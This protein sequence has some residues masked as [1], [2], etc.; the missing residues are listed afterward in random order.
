MQTKRKVDQAPPFTIIRA[1]CRAALAQP[2]EAVAQQVRRLVDAYVAA[3]HAAEAKVLN[4][5]LEGTTSDSAFASSRLVRS[6]AAT[7]GEDLSTRTPPPVDRETSVPLAELIFDSALPTTPPIFNPNVEAGL[8]SLVEEWAHWEALQAVGIEPARSCLIYG[9]PGTGK[10]KLAL[11]MAEQ[12][13]L[14][15]VLARL[16][17]LVSS[18]LGTTS[19]NIGTLFQFANRYRCVLM[20]DEF[21]AIAKVRDDPHEVGEIKR[22]DRKSTR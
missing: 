2:N 1:L 19:R 16:D 4:E 13:G 8:R 21:D 22:V 3:G 6:H 7:S 15:V 9:A 17:G 11:W 20:L 10:T 14:P 12:L 18:F 5:L